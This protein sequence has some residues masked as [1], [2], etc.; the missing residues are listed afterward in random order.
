MVSELKSKIAKNLSNIAGWRT[1]RKIVVIES[2]DWGSIRMPSLQAFDRLKAKGLP[3]GYE[4]ALRYNQNDT[5]ASADDFAHLFEVLHQ[6]KDQ[7]GRPAVFTAMSLVANPDFEKIKENN[8]NQYYYEPVTATINKY[9][10][11][12]DVF[13]LWQEGIAHHLFIPQFHGREHLNVAAWMKALQENDPFTHAAFEEGCWGFGNKHP[14]NVKYQAAFDVTDPAEIESQKLI[15]QD[16]LRL[17]EKIFGYKAS[18]FVPPNGPFNNSLEEVAATEGIQF[19]SCSKI[20]HEPLG[21]GKTRKQLHYIGQKNQHGQVYLTRNCF[22]EP[23]QNRTGT[24]ENCL[25]EINIAFR[26]NKPAIISSHRVNYIGVHHEKNRQQ[27]LAQLTQ[28]LTAIQKQWPDVEFMTSNQ[29]GAL[30]LK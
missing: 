26:W 7:H 4:D 16:G 6:F 17:F 5:L 1:K 10:P 28:L 24:V 29:L 25:S 22:F 19:M 18:F 14:Y 3:I 30:M 21:F 11:Q 9:H 2:D 23:S 27:G 13:K 8:F 20:Q 12:H 15:I